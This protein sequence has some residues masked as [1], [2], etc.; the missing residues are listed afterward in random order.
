MSRLILTQEREAPTIK[1][2]VFV[3]V[4]P[5][6][7]TKISTRGSRAEDRRIVKS[8]DRN[9]GRKLNPLAL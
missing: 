7:A 4:S 9:G 3:T 6:S 1:Y 5:S 8:S 2:A